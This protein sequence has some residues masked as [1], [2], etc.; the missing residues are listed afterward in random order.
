VLFTVIG[1]GIGVVVLMLAGLLSKHSG[2]AA[3]PTPAAAS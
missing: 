1:V 3:T 2:K